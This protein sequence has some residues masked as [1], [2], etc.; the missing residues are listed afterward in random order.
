V[1]STPVRVW[2]WWGRLAALCVI[3]ASA[4]LVSYSAQAEGVLFP[5][6]LHLTRRIEDPLAK[7]ASVVHEYCA[8]NRVVTVSGERVA[9]AD[10]A[11]QELTEIDRAAGTYSVT[12]FAQ[13]ANAQP[14]APGRTASARAEAAQPR[15]KKALLGVRSSAAGRSMDAFA[16]T[17]DRPSGERV[18]IELGVDRS[19]RLSREALEVLIGASFPNPRGEEHDAILEAAGVGTAGDKSLV[20]ANSAGALDY[21]LPVDQVTAYEIAG[22]RITVRNAVVDVRQELPPAE[23]LTIPPGATRVESRAVRLARELRELDRLP[24]S[25]H[26]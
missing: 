4:V 9:I 5:Q 15:W 17:F 14:A 12:S 24:S 13:L 25:P 2:A 6:P 22:E 11:R 26:P 8:G 18:Q 19:V 16:L 23:L 10:Y 3:G 7:T 20:T 1:R 21:G